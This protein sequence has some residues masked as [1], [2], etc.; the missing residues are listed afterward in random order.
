[1]HSSS[2]PFVLH[3]LPISSSLTQ[4]TYIPE[5]LQSTVGSS[6]DYNQQL[7][8]LYS[9]YEMFSGEKSIC[10]RQNGRMGKGRVG[11]L[12]DLSQRNAKLEEN[13]SVK[14]NDVLGCM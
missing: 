5:H 10:S 14:V 11:V 9:V 3:A 2:P 7:V 8:E 12:G 13:S 4:I 6:E 1:M